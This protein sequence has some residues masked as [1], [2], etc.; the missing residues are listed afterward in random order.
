ML[1]NENMTKLYRHP[2][3]STPPPK[4]KSLAHLEKSDFQQSTKTQSWNYV[5]RIMLLRAFVA[6]KKAIY[7]M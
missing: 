1:G 2:P 4:K 7:S 3:R 5:G 6:T